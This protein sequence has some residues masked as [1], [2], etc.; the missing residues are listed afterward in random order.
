MSTDPATEKLGELLRPSSPAEFFARL[1]EA[2]FIH[3]RGEARF[4]RTNLLGSD[5]G[6]VL[7][8][9][10]ATLAPK[11]GFHAVTPT[12]PPPGI[13]P[14]ASEDDFRNR[15]RLFHERGY[16]VRFPD[17][18]LFSPALDV[19]ARALESRVH[20][21]VTAAAFWSKGG[22]RAP[23]HFDD[24]DII[25]VQLVG[26]KEWE[27]SGAPS[28]LRTNQMIMPDEAVTSVPE[29]VRVKMRAGDLLYVPRGLAHTVEG[30][31]ESLHISFMFHPVTLRDALVAAIDELARVD[32]SFREAIAGDV[33]GQLTKA[34][35]QELVPS[36]LEAINRL[37]HS[38]GSAEFLQ[39]SLRK[40]SGRAIRGMEP[41][42]TV[43]EAK[44]GLDTRLKQNESALCVLVQGERMIELNYP[45]D[46]IYIHRGVQEA[47]TFMVEQPVFRLSDV[48]GD[49]PA[50]ILIALAGK[51][52]SIGHLEL[53]VG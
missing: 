48:P 32:R 20:Q 2:R 49:L 30:E 10:W 12:G 1:R 39:T 13:G 27:V 6:E 14:A 8:A 33:R 42:P 16:S 24:R 35:A 37:Q 45:G 7:I 41:L 21:P 40:R 15:I 26:E 11:I 47:L 52:L 46:K 3:I 31:I 18:R 5:P 36:V 51:L 25:A 22:L 28:P 44:I 4:E 53:C 17:L 34:D 50:D 23:V 29:P 9:N 38:T 43:P 19:M